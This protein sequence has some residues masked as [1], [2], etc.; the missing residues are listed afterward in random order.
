MLGR[1]LGGLDSP[2]GMFPQKNGGGVRPHMGIALFAK[3]GKTLKGI[4]RGC[5]ISFALAL[6]KQTKSNCAHKYRNLPPRS[7][8]SQRHSQILRDLILDLP[9]SASLRDMGFFSSCHLSSLG[10]KDLRTPMAEG[11]DSRRVPQGGQSL[12]TDPILRP[13]TAPAAARV[14][15]RNSIAQTPKA[16]AMYGPEPSTCDKS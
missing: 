1:G 12:K 10:G 11:I 8:F 7:H 4:G 16:H 13:S 5:A 3:E 14:E 6:R 15:A 9:S 2:F